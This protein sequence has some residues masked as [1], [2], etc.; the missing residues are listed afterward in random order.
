MNILSKLARH[1]RRLAGLPLKRKV[2]YMA[3]SIHG[4]LWR[5]RGRGWFGPRLIEFTLTH[6]CQCRCEHCYVESDEP[7]A[8]PN[9][10]TTNEVCGYL[11]QAAALGC[12]EVCFTGGEPLM[13]EDLCKLIAH[14]RQLHMVSKINSNGLML[15]PEMISALKQAGLGWCSV[16]ID[17]PE[18]ETHNRLRRFRGCYEQ[19]VAG[20][21]E[22]VR[23]GVPASITT[24][25]ERGRLLRGDME[26][27][28][29]LGHDIGVETVRILFPV[30]MGGFAH[31]Q[32]KV[33]HL[34]EREAVRELLKDPLV[35]MESPREGTRCTAAV[36]KFNVLPDATVTPCVFVPLSFGNLRKESLRKI[37]RRM[38]KFDE[39]CKPNGQCPMCN[40]Q[41]REDLLGGRI[42]QL[43]RPTAVSEVLTVRA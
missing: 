7:I 20:L 5:R 36:T 8:S 32:E 37:W 18:P 23:Q 33:L 31:Q 39:L 14:A 12:T 29:K 24:Y 38:A 13:R 4:E 35:T 6:R 9:E 41:F 43:E 34:E 11:N 16:S 19:A 3:Q 1:H 25:A 40:E 22:L 28:V 2:Y 27:I 21:R 17:S 30:P 10:M 15:T 42:L 26:R